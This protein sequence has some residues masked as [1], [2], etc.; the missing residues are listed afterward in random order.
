MLTTASAALALPLVLDESASAASRAVV[1]TSKVPVGGG[2]VVASRDVV[3]TRPRKKQFRVFS[4]ACTH[5]G[6]TV[7]GVSGRTINCA[8]H[9][10]KFAIGN[11]GVTQGPASSPLP[12]VG[13]R[14]KRGKIYLT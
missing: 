5:Q 2:V 12:A 11:G 13:F 4:A 9:G 10:S 8:C 14:I 1:K 6:C 3:V 7:A